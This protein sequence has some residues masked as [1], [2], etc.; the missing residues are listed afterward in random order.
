MLLILQQSLHLLPSNSKLILENFDPSLRS[1]ERVEYRQLGSL[2]SNWVS[3]DDTIEDQSEAKP[4][5]HAGLRNAP[6]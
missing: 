4:T 5:N 6:T 1:F 2:I 3:Y